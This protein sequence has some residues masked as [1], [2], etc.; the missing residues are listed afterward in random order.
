M[1]KPPLILVAEPAVEGF[2][3][4]FPRE[5]DAPKEVPL[6]DTAVADNLV[7]ATG[8]RTTLT[9][10]VKAWELENLTGQDVQKSAIEAANF[11]AIAPGVGRLWNTAYIDTAW[12]SFV[13][14]EAMSF[15]VQAGTRD[16]LKGASYSLNQDRFIVTDAPALQAS[17]L[18]HL[19][20]VTDKEEAAFAAI[21]VSRLKQDGAALDAT[22]LKQGVTMTTYQTL[23]N[24]V[25]DDASGNLYG[26]QGNGGF[27]IDTGIVAMGMAMVATKIESQRWRDGERDPRA[28]NGSTWRKAA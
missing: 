1:S 28:T 26:Q 22:A 21:A 4:E 5:L 20:A 25:L 18:A 12:N 15:A 23:F 19:S 16:W 3:C 17:L 27:A 24:A 10:E 11:G 2:S 13:Q 7:T 8:T 6:R 14:R 9:T